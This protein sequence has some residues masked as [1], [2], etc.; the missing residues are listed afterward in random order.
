MVIGM[1]RNR[2]RHEPGIVIGF[3]GIRTVPTTTDVCDPATLLLV[4]SPH[5]VPGRSDDQV[6]RPLRHSPTHDL[7]PILRAPDHV[8]FQIK[9]RVRAMPIFRHPLIVEDWNGPLKA[10]RRKAVGLDPAIEFEPLPA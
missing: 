4:Q 5:L 1:P 2:D 9:H 7:V 8:I 6:A 3:A 10:D